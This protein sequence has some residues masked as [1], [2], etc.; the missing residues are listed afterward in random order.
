MGSCASTQSSGAADAILIEPMGI[1]NAFNV[2]QVSEDVIQRL[3]GN[4]AR[5]NNRYDQNAE[6]NNQLLAEITSKSALIE[7]RLKYNNRSFNIKLLEKKKIVSKPKIFVE[8]FA[9]AETNTRSAP[10]NMGERYSYRREFYLREEQRQSRIL[11]EELQRSKLQEQSLRE[12]LSKSESLLEGLKSQSIASVNTTNYASELDHIS[13]ARESAKDHFLEIRFYQQKLDEVLQQQ[14]NWQRELT[15]KFERNLANFEQNVRA[16]DFVSFCVDAEN[17]VL[18]C[19][20][21]N[22]K[23]TL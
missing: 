18:K 7:Q 8:N 2:V 6:A 3:T 1:Q 5:N 4:A 14:E 16:H 22:P 19:Y 17:A 21:E 23:Q 10:K 20:Q 13:V 15:T 12:K 9:F 11:K